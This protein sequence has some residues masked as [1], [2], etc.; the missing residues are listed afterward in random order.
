MA[1]AFNFPGVYVEEIAHGLRPIEGAPTAITAF[2]GRAL[3]GPEGQAVDIF[4][5]ADYERQFGGLWLD[6]AMSYAVRDFFANGGGHA[7][8]VRLFHAD[9]AGSPPRILESGTLRFRAA[10]RGSWADQ[11]EL[12]VSAGAAADAF[13]LT[14]TD[15][16]PGGVMEMYEN[17]SLKNGAR[18]VD[19]ML[20]GVSALVQWAG[21]N[22][23]ADATAPALP[24]LPSL[25]AGGLTVPPVAG[26]ASDGT[27]LTA[28]DFLDPDCGLRA[29]DQLYA[30]NSLFN[31]LV[32]PPYNTAGNIDDTVTTA[33]IACCELRRAMLLLDAPAEWR[34]PVQAASQFPGRFHALSP[35]AALYFPRVDMPN[36]LR[37]N[38]I[39]SFAAAGVVAGAF[40]RND[41]QRGVWKAPAGLEVV[42]A[43]VT[44]PSVP[45]TDGENGQLNA[46]GINCLRSFAGRGNVVWG[47]R[48]L[49]GGDDLGDPFKYVPVRRTALFIEESLYRG[50]QW[51]AFEPNDESLWAQIRY[52]AGDFMNRLFTQGAFQGSAARDAYLVRCDAA[53]TTPDDA[54][55]GM[56]N[57]MVGFAPL[58]P[59]D[60][61]V[62]TLQLPVGAGLM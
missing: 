3:R 22:L 6:S 14:V 61:V 32:I 12:S 27:P 51:V 9:A 40:A 26:S 1:A 53:T 2:V 43:G 44:A 30:R 59:A 57:L 48:T 39:E 20:K 56:V 52:N 54:V 34:D 35:N 42:M 45:V 60:F 13:N 62:L 11:L 5:F 4:S 28:D 33:A 36:P 29:L 18:R 49:R 46:L 41:A 8:I 24:A 19:L 10:S 25:P 17:V 58:R 47:A 21:A 15:R 7:V 38:R 23:D 31:L 37:G 16:A 50:L 55:R